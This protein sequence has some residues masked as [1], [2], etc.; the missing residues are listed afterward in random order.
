MEDTMSQTTSQ[1]T[2]EGVIEAPMEGSKN[3][4]QAEPTKLYTQAEL[5]AITAAVR[6]TTEKKILKKFEGID[7]EAYKSLVQ[8]EEQLKLEEQKR[9]GEFEKILKETADKAQQKIQTLSSELAKIKVD[10]ALI[11]AAST[12]KA[13]NPEQVA[14]LVRDQ[15]RM[16]EAGE[17]EVIDPKSG[18]VKYTETGDPMTI[19][20]LVSDW[21][22]INSHFVAAGPAGGGSKSNTSS[23]GAK[24]VDVSKLD[25]NNPADRAIYKKLRPQIFGTKNIK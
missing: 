1:A 22:K 15:V 18:Q 20:N 8:K 3:T 25:L 16:S 17:V 6:G 2:T 11:N 5:D 7:V 19:E 23:E 12:K 21:L 9:K 4:T 14:R 24:E 10:G 13:I